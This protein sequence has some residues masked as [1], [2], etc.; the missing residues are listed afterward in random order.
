MPYVFVSTLGVTA[1]P[2]V[3]L[4]FSLF[5]L[6]LVPMSASESAY[7]LIV[8]VE[9]LLSILEDVVW[10]DRNG[11]QTAGKL[12]LVSKSF[13]QWADYLF[14][15]T[16]VVDD[17]RFSQA[18]M[19]F[20]DAMSSTQTSPRLRSARQKIQE[21]SVRTLNPIQPTVLRQL[22]LCCPNLHSIYLWSEPL[23]KGIEKL[24]CP[25][26]RVLH[27][28]KDKKTPL[29][30]FSSQFFRT[31]THLELGCT[32]FALGAGLLQQA[33]D[34]VSMQQLSHLAFDGMY[35]DRSRFPEEILANLHHVPKTVQVVLVSLRS[36]MFTAL[37]TTYRTIPWIN[38]LRVVA[39]L[40]PKYEYE[41]PKEVV[42]GNLFDW[43]ESTENGRPVSR[44]VYWKKAERIVKA[45]MRQV[46]YS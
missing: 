46:G 41:M 35:I 42:K 10:R 20:L 25:S 26:L 9:I 38:D 29:A 40:R 45:R 39:C 17:S 43:S 27:F 2:D 23:P 8:P 7:D 21:L 12:C 3:G 16:I 30:P 5:S 22:V 4:L 1:S 34:L 13:Q 32:D 14:F 6:I 33:Q 11:V 18:H 19:E 24:P 37:K 36:S 31:V 28:K 15:H 44:D